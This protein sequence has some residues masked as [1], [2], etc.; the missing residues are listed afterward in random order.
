MR[1]SLRGWLDA[2]NPLRA[3]LS[4]P[5]AHNPMRASLRQERRSPN[6]P[7]GHL[8][9]SGGTGVW[10]HTNPNRASL[11]TASQ[12]PHRCKYRGSRLRSDLFLRAISCYVLHIHPKHVLHRFA[13]PMLPKTAPGAGFSTVPQVNQ[14]HW[15]FIE[16]ADAR[17]A[18]FRRELTTICTLGAGGSAASALGI[19]NTGVIGAMGS[20]R[21]A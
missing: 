11:Q 9:G 17:C 21:R 10:M 4:R 3:S 20:S 12:P 8:G 15:V 19:L 16:F 6:H 18:T 1:A 5:D 2:H 7:R 14:A 13:F